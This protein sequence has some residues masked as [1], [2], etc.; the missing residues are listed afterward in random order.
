MSLTTPS[1]GQVSAYRGCVSLAKARAT[2]LSHGRQ[3]GFVKVTNQVQ[4]DWIVW[5]LND[6]KEPTAT[7]MELRRDAENDLV[8][9]SV[10]PVSRSPGR[11][12]VAVAPTAPATMEEAGYRLRVEAIR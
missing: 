5:V 2:R 11:L 8:V 9:G 3:M 6:A 1:T 12:V 7:R 4:Q 10:S